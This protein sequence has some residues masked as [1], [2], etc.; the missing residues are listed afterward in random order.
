[1][2]KINLQKRYLFPLVLI[3]SLFFLWGVANNLNDILI[4]QFKKAFTLS[5]F[6]S[7][8]VQSAFYFGYFCFSIPAAIFMQRLGYKAAVIIGLG[9]YAS[10]ALLFYP[11][12][13]AQ[14]YMFFLCAL[15]VIASGLAFLET[16]ANPLIIVMGEPEGAAR[17]LNL[18]QSFNP[19][20]AISGVL[21]GREFILSGVE[22]DESALAAM[23][24]AE[25]AAF[26]QSEIEAVQG[27]YLVIAAVV[28]LWLVLVALSKFPP[29]ANKS[30]EGE[31]AGKLHDF[32]ALLKKPFFLF[33]VCAQFFYVGAQ[34]GIWSFM[35]RYGQH[36]VPG[37]GEKSLATYLTWSL[38]AFMIGR[39]VATA[40]MHRMVPAR[41]MLLFSLANIALCL[42]AILVPTHSGLLALAATSFFMSLMFP[43]IFA[44]ALDGL[45]SLTKAGSSFLVMAIIG[46]AVLTA[47]MG[48]ISDLSSM[49]IA[50][51]VPMLC[52]VV[53]AAFAYVA[54]GRRA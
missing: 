7:G 21:I 20:G 26:K 45:G 3:V 36:A 19:L 39:F 48:K 9:L 54:M 16:S 24:A 37:T 33:G 17:R 5:D 32:A 53:I 27:P 31:Q 47:L 2:S 35:I 14:T 6:Q 25:Q 13:E 43:T 23:S 51:V 4:A 12:A 30:I 11:A 40:L 44:L 52:F 38:V 18:A 28:V 1:M 10:G 50:M 41:L 42:F 8:L 46:G 29:V 49:N 15:F 34:V 22:H